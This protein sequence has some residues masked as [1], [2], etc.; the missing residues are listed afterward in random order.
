MG[1]SLA[2][3][4]LAALSGNCREIPAL[5]YAMMVTVRCMMLRLS[6]LAAGK[7]VWH[8]ASC[9]AYS[10]GRLSFLNKSSAWAQTGC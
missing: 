8:L 3:L 6:S 4:R 9:S 5:A 1:T 10:V 7:H 2:A